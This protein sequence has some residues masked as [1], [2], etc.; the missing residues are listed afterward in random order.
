MNPKYRGVTFSS[1]EKL[2]KWLKEHTKYIVNID[3]N[4]EGFVTWHLDGAGEILYSTTL[5][6]L[7]KGRMVDLKA[8]D[9][10]NELILDGKTKI[11]YRP[12]SVEVIV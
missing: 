9:E 6:H 8:L 11:K 10:R 5:N 4:G 1:A 7:W 12:D 3:D 2:E